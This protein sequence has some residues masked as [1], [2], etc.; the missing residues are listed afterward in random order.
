MYPAVKEQQS[1]SISGGIALIGCGAIAELFYLPAIAKHKAIRENLILVDRSET[2]AKTMA[3][4]FDVKNYATD[5]RKVLESGLAGAIIALPTPLHHPAILDFLSKGVHVLSEK[6]LAMTASEAKQLVQLAE[7]VQV[8][9][10]MNQTRR[11]FPSYMKVKE[12]LHQA[13]LGKPLSIDYREGEDFRWPTTS[14][15]YFNS[16]IS[17]RG[18]LLDRGAHVLDLVCWWLDN[19]P[20]ILSCLTDSFGGP[21]AIAEVE[22]RHHLCFGKLKFSFLGKVS[23]RFAITCEDGRIEGDIHDFQ[24]IDLVS[25]NGTRKKLKLDSREKTFFDFGTAVVANFINVI[26]NSGKPRV[27]GHEV[28]DAMECIDECYRIA[29]QFPMPWYAI[30]RVSHAP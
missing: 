18:V 14:G 9:L 12:I 29:T 23:S 30:G 28:L 3:E 20:Q 25:K 7:T 4:K 5:Y 26:T 27:S 2:R 24:N 1:A 10:C 13:E 19:K 22:F 6:P 8:K 21:E 11:F 16:K 17:S 15:F